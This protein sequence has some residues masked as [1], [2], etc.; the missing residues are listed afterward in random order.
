M[1]KGYKRGNKLDFPAGDMFWAK[2]K[3]VYQIFQIDLRKDIFDEGKGPQTFLFAIE[4]IWLYI[5]KYNGYYYKKK[6]GYY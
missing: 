5:V 1:F 3:A 4:R 2:C 6:C